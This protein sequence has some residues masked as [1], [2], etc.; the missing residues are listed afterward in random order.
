MKQTLIIPETHKDER[1]DQTLAKLLPDFSR[2]QIKE[3]IEAGTILMNGQPVK[4][5]TRVKGGE[6]ISVEVVI[7]PQPVWEAQAI[8]LSIV[9]ED[10]ALIVIN[11]PAGLVVHPG[12]GNADRT[13]LNA[14]LHH[15]PA[16]Q[17]LP[18]AGILHRLDKDTS[19]LLVIAKTPAALKDLSH[20]LKKR[21]LLREYQAI[22]WGTLISGGTVD[23]PIGRHGLQRKRMAVTESGK[24]SVTHYRVAEKFRAH[25]R[26]KLRLETGRTHQIRVHM[27]HIHHPIVGDATYGGRVQLAKG[28]QPELIQQLRQFKRQALHAYALGLTHPETGEFIRWEIE[29]PSDMKAL[30]SALRED[31]KRSRQ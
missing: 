20:Q 25:T 3:W 8:P 4:A 13:L 1:L 30:I 5:K 18:R 24:Q 19:G 16:L 12:A 22:V 6:M 11:K 28:M 29:L 26:L 31:M 14:L 27:A 23:A 17:A 2:T 7:K 10:E 9:Y 21:T 15:A